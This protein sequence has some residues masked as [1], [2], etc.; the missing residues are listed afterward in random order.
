MDLW[1]LLLGTTRAVGQDARRV[2]V[3]EDLHQTLLLFTLLMPNH[4]YLCSS[5]HVNTQEELEAERLHPFH[6]ERPFATS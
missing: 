6:N 3:T 4:A 5:A 1:F 2:V